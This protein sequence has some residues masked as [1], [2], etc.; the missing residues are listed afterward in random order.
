VDQQHEQEDTHMVAAETGMTTEAAPAKPKRKRRA[1]AG[2]PEVGQKAERKKPNTLAAA[3][4][5]MGEHHPEALRVLGAAFKERLREALADS[6]SRAVCIARV[7]A[8]K[9]RLREAEA[10][11][12]QFEDGDPSAALVKALHETAAFIAKQRSVAGPDRE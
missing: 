9:E 11:L 10:A 4:R 6:R 5:A 1:R 2:K 7:A 8:A 3:V 12:A